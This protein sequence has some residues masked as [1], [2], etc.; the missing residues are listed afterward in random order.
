MSSL[1]HKAAS[2]VLAAIPLL[3]LIHPAIPEPFNM[4]TSLFSMQLELTK[5][6]GKSIAN[7]LKAQHCNK[8]CWSSLI[9]SLVWWIIHM[10]ALVSAHVP[11]QTWHTSG[12]AQHTHTHSD[13]FAGKAT[14][15]LAVLFVG[16]LVVHGY[17]RSSNNCESIFATSN[18]TVGCAAFGA[19]VHTQNLSVVRADTQ[20]HDGFARSLAT[21]SAEWVKLLRKQKKS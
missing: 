5:K 1:C 19:F 7:R 2:A 8:A 12:T 6:W 11:A 16:T 18:C 20:R 10:V 9:T 15:S 13:V 14:M 21:V 3:P 4:L 17:P